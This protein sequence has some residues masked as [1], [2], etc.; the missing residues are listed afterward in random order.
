MKARDALRVLVIDDDEEHAMII[1]DLLREDAQYPFETTWCGDAA[2]PGG[3][4]RPSATRST[5]WTT[6]WVRQA[7]SS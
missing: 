6:G 5:S 3:C 7:V 1:A 2:A 4:S